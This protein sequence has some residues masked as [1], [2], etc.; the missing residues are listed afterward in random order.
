MAQGCFEI[1]H[2]HQWSQLLARLHSTQKD[3][4]IQVINNVKDFSELADVIIKGLAGRTSKPHLHGV[5]HYTIE[6]DPEDN[7]SV[8]AR[9]L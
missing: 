2:Q 1:F 8:L 7:D 5:Y 6:W 4:I 9:A 3:H